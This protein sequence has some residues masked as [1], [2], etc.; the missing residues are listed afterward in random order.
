MKK[1]LT[2]ILLSFAMMSG[3]TSF[4]IA[5]VGRP[6][7]STFDELAAVVDS[8]ATTVEITR[9]IVIDAHK[10]LG[11]DDKTIT[12]TRS[13][14]FTEDILL[15][16]ENGTLKNLI[17]DGQSIGAHERAVWTLD[18]CN[19]ENVTFTNCSAGAVEV[20]TGSAIFSNCTFTDNSSDTGAHVLIGATAIFS[21]CV[22]T[23]GK[24][25]DSAGA[26]RNNGNLTL[27]NCTFAENCTSGISTFQN[28]GAIYNANT[29]HAENCEFNENNSILGGAIDTTGGGNTELLSCVFTNN[30]ATVG[31]AINNSGITTITD[32]LIYKN[33][34]TEEGADLSAMNPITVLFTENYVFD[35]TPSGWHSDFYTERSGSKLFD[36]SFEGSGKLVFLMVSDL[37]TSEPEPDPN[38]EPK[39]EPEP[40]P[41]VAPTEP[42]FDTDPPTATVKPSTQ[43]H[44]TVVDVKTIKPTLDKANMLYLVGY[45]DAVSDDNIT[46]RQIVHILYNLMSDECKE[47]YV[48]EESPFVD[49]V[50]D[51]PIAVLAKAKIIVGYDEHYRPDAYLTMGELCTILSRFSELESGTSSFQNIEHHWARDYVNI[52]VSSGW[53]DDSREIDLNEYVDAKDTID[54]IVKLL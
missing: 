37:P 46:R 27:T 18:D 50:D 16:V 39:P 33:K 1:R 8:G 14:D 4:A 15:R 52:C 49:V 40:T 23:G 29:L 2:A 44:N 43:H 12:L 13:A 3:L 22:F 31:G 17:I 48:C 20:K 30:S 36:L 28:G 53:I 45:R 11:Y 51:I 42:D 32:T 5:D 54:I 10:V 38:P 25:E 24:A 19:F 26:I 34:A 47:Y 9:T 41:P 7:A 6:T 21:D 35:E